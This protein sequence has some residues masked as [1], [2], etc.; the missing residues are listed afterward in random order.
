MSSYNDSYWA[1]ETDLQKFGDTLAAKIRDHDSQTLISAINYRTARAY[2]YYFGLD[3]SGVHGTSQVL[4]GGDIGE[5]AVVRVNHARPLLNTLLNLIVAPKVVWQPKATNIDYQSL[6]ETEL[7]SAVLEYYWSEKQVS[8]LAVVALEQALAFCEAFIKVSWDTDAGDEYAGNLENNQV[9]KTGD[10]SFKNIPTWDVLRDSTKGSFDALDCLWVREWRNKF[11]VAAQYPDFRDDVLD[12]PQELPINRGQPIL[13]RASDCDDIPVYTFF[14]KRRPSLPNGRETVCLTTG[15]ILTD[16][17]LSYSEIPLYRVSAGEM[18]GTP[19]GYSPFLDILGI[20]EVMDSLHT[21][22]SSNQTTFG[23]QVIAIEDGSNVALDSLVGGMKALYYPAGSTKVPEALQLVK[24]PSELFTYVKDLKSA[25]EL[26][27]GLNSVV[28]GEPQSGEQSGSALALLQSQALQQSSTI[29]A[30]YLRMIEGLGTCTIQIIQQRADVPKK[31]AIVGKADASLVTDQEFTGTED[32][33][34]IKRVQVEIGSPAS[35]TTAGRI[36]VAR[37]LMQ[38]GMIKSPEQYLQVIETGKLKPLTHSLSSQLMLI[39]K[40]NEQL[41]AAKFD[42]SAPPAPP[43]VDPATGRQIPADPPLDAESMPAVLVLDDHQLH[44]REHRTVLDDP[45]ARRNPAVVKAVLMHIDQH[46]K[47]LYSTPPQTLLLVG[48]QPPQIMQPPPGMSPA[49]NGP[50][51]PT[52]K[53][54]PPGGPAEQPKP[55]VQPA[56]GKRWDPTSAGGVV[57]KPST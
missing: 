46:E 57:P 37:E 4:R 50:P 56:T 40:E 23:G 30:N 41:Q 42:K 54:K 22:I 19:Y 45:N 11:D 8:R 39:A 18:T 20:Q 25:Q 21:T 29:Q 24:T 36:E 49:G 53:G 55:P 35:Q 2:R 3:P 9:I 17:D 27:F 31:I 44:A 43:M 48:Q 28:R 51:L 52:P 10:L 7:A 13:Q 15:R 38:N 5:L 1:A 14:H 16:S 33:T 34:G 32:L 6:R 12:A 26:V 47:A